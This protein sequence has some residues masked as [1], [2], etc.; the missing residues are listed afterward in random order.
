MSGD[1]PVET[2]KQEVEAKPI[3]LSASVSY[4]LYMPQEAI[5][6]PVTPQQS[7]VTGFVQEC[8]SPAKSDCKEPRKD[9]AKDTRSQMSEEKFRELL[10]KGSSEDLRRLVLTQSKMLKCLHARMDE[11]KS[12][13]EKRE[14]ARLTEKVLKDMSSRMDALGKTI[15]ARTVAATAD[16]KKGI[17][18]GKIDLSTNSARLKFE[19][20]NGNFDV[21]SSSNKLTFKTPEGKVSYSV[22]DGQLVETRD[23][24]DRVIGSAATRESYVFKDGA[25]QKVDPNEPCTDSKN[26]II[27]LGGGCGKT[28]DASIESH[29]AAVSF[30]GAGD[31]KAMNRYAENV[32]SMAELQRK[33]SEAGL[34]G[35]GHCGGGDGKGNPGDQPRPVSSRGDNWGG[36][37]PR[38]SGSTYGSGREQASGSTSQVAERSG[39]AAVT[40]GDVSA[41]ARWE[42]NRSNTAVARA[43]EQS[44]SQTGLP[45]QQQITERVIQPAVQQI[46]SSNLSPLVRSADMPISARQAAAESIS[47][48]NT[49]QNYYKMMQANAGREQ[50][51]QKLTPI[52]ATHLA[53]AAKL[54]L[55]LSQQQPLMS[56]PGLNSIL[57][58]S[59][60]NNPASPLLKQIALPNQQQPQPYNSFAKQSITSADPLAKPNLAAPYQ[61]LRYTNP[62]SFN[63][64]NKTA[65]GALN[66]FG[67][68]LTEMQDTTKATGKNIL[69][70]HSRPN[71]ISDN[72]PATHTRVTDKWT[73]VKAIAGGGGHAAGGDAGP[74]IPISGRVGGAGAST[75]ARA[76]GSRLGTKQDGGGSNMADGGKGVQGVKSVE[77]SRL[78]GGKKIEG[79]P[80]DGGKKIEPTKNNQG[81]KSGNDVVDDGKR[82]QG[83]QAVKSAD[84]TTSTA[85]GAIRDNAILPVGPGGNFGGATPPIKDTKTASDKVEQIAQSQP[86]AATQKDLGFGYTPR[87]SAYT[88]KQGDSLESIARKRWGDERLAELIRTINLHRLNVAKEGG[89]AVLRL[90]AGDVI[91]L[92]SPIEA[93]RFKKVCD[94]KGDGQHALTVGFSV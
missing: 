85:G 36:S 18:C 54:Q 57:K 37:I 51:V 41:L 64:L 38:G 56:Q 43:A 92:P 74:F 6:E 94:I 23:K 72:A 12:A 5:K 32:K 46:S 11:A 73:P 26:P 68:S 66:S 1:I 4:D 17:E 80:V 60:M 45:A 86:E 83:V 69:G 76:E 8:Y 2:K 63:Q 14:M 75:G 78:N 13:E 52:S 55:P 81:V 42:D 22:K 49:A 67:K 19:T 30:D 70:G 88:I 3:V 50:A 91:W 44:I 29:G 48:V 10:E 7:G 89:Q 90:A 31:Q 93:E 84:A 79:N 47:A 65:N 35:S 62:G 59:I 87:R 24:V 27:Q 40:R 71:L 33:T 82:I 15:D 28:L 58:N 61:A 16:I 21:K 77:G 9:T 25:L 34:P 39:G 53:D 20:A